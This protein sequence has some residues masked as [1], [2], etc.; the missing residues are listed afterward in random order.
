MEKWS[1]EWLFQ[2][3]ARRFFVQTN[4][5]KRL[6]CPFFKC[7]LAGAGLAALV[8]GVCTQLC[9]SQTHP[10]AWSSPGIWTTLPPLMGGPTEAR[11]TG[12]CPPRHPLSPTAFPPWKVPSVAG[13]LLRVYSRQ[14]ASC[15]GHCTGSQ[16]PGAPP[17]LHLSPGP[18]PC[19]LQVGPLVYR[20]EI[21]RD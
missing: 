2:L 20:A 5:F 19:R 12:T 1:W 17:L 18:A 14:P 9:L 21:V 10:L 4:V 15:G 8:A 11:P 7:H 16:G 13:T 3:C 6:R